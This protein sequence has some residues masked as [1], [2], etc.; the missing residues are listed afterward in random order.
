MK[1]P[2]IWALLC[3]L[4]TGLGFVYA[5]YA[6][7]RTC[8]ISKANVRSGAGAGY[9]I[10]AELAQG[11][12]VDVL[13]ES[14]GWL[15][16]KTSNDVLGWI[17][18]DLTTES[19]LEKRKCT[20]DNTNI[21][22]GPGTAYIVIGTLT[23]GQELDIY[24]IKD[25]WLKIS[26]PD[27]FG[28]VFAGYTTASN[29][30]NPKNSGDSTLAVVIVIAIVAFLLVFSYI[31]DSRNKRCPK[32]G[33]WRAQT[34]ISRDELNRQGEYRNERVEEVIRDEHRHRV[35]SVTRVK[36]VHHT[37]VTYCDHYQCKYCKYQW[38]GNS[39]ETYEG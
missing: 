38:S 33:K 3:L 16:I 25:Q 26:L 8:N 4:I 19:L 34:M 2:L 1:K 37:T 18:K 32:C 21:R 20:K 29:L 7:K 24:A 27:G 10:V 12:T 35:A 14:N 22:S 11:D 39:K 13:Q 28:W 5:E 36:P 17:R 6:E 23:E 9:S 31:W 15:Q 30:E